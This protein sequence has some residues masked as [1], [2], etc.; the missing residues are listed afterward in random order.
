[1]L[2]TNKKLKRR[3]VTLVEV[4]MVLGVMAILLG[5]AMTIYSSV[6]TTQTTNA[7]KE[8][9]LTLLDT[10]RQLSDSQAYNN[11][12]SQDD[13]Y[14]ATLAKSGLIPKRYVAS[15][16]QNI[17]SSSGSIIGVYSNGW[18]GF[19]SFVLSGVPKPECIKLA[20]STWGDTTNIH[21]I[22]INGY[23]NGVYNQEALSPQQADDA[24][25]SSG[26]TI[27]INYKL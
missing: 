12:V 21:D 20:T 6:R 5:L 13:T 17:V 1:M 3:G 25:Q 19:V 14:G 27:I 8:E 11:Q 26:S 4:M 2:I 7:D 15:D 23:G 18:G 10:Y 9:I 16:N 22:N 24:C